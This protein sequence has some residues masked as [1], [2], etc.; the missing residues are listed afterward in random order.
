MQTNLWYYLKQHRAM[1]YH[2]AIEGIGQMIYQKWL[3]ID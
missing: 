1:Y 3:Y 2:H